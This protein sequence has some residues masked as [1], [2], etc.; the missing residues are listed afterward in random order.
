MSFGSN[1]VKFCTGE[2]T[3]RQPLDSDK[4]RLDFGHNEYVLYKEKKV[5]L[6]YVILVDTMTP[7]LG[8]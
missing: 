1:Q 6:R 3:M 8:L 7:L 2:P 4:R 5:R